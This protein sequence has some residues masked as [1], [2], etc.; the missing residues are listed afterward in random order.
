[1]FQLHVSRGTEGL[2]APG[3]PCVRAGEEGA[4]SGLGE[5]ES[6]PGLTWS[7]GSLSQGVLTESPKMAALGPGP[8]EW[9]QREGV[10]R[11]QAGFRLLGNV[12]GRH[13]LT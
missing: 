1:M 5:E 7:S 6:R 4:V 12:P 13:I 9:L 11:S 8:W 3:E 10:F 2:V